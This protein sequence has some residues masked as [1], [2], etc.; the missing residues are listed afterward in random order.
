MKFPWLRWSTGASWSSPYAEVIRAEAA[1]R[2]VLNRRRGKTQRLVVIYLGWHSSLIVSNGMSWPQHDKAKMWQCEVGHYSH[3][4]PMLSY[5][6]CAIL[7]I[8]SDLCTQR[9]LHPLLPFEARVMWKANEVRELPNSPFQHPWSQTAPY[10]PRGPKKK[11][12]GGCFFVDGSSVSW[13]GSHTQ[14]PC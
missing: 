6:P 12:G 8:L 7:D 1:Q 13:P 4:V 2:A 3:L 11:E 10:G 9:C 5:L 14:K